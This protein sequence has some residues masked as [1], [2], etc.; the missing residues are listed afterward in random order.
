MGSRRTTH[1]RDGWNENLPRSIWIV[2]RYMKVGFKIKNKSFED[3]TLGLISGDSHSH[4]VVVERRYH[5]NTRA[6][7]PGLSSG[8][9]IYEWRFVHHIGCYYSL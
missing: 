9:E 1:W 2:Q 6:L 5:G 8:E 7:E 3:W 4:L